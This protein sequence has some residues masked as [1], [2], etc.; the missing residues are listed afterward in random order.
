MTESEVIDAAREAGGRYHPSD[1]PE[2]KTWSCVSE[3]AFLIRFAAI[4]SAKQK[5]KDA[6]ICD[7]ISDEWGER[8]DYFPGGDAA[9]EECANAIRGQE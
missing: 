3:T 1:W 7:G 2:V 6:R 8:S 9:A 5:E 4:I